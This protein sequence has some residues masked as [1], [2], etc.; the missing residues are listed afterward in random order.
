LT[1]A[2]LEIKRIIARMNIPADVS[3]PK[4]M[5]AESARYVEVH[6]HCEHCEKKAQKEAAQMEN[7]A[8]LW[9]NSRLPSA[10]KGLRFDHMDPERTD[11]TA[12][13]DCREWEYGPR[14]LYLWGATGV[15]KTRLSQCLARREIVNYTRRVLFLGL[16]QLFADLKESF[17]TGSP[18]PRR[19]LSAARDVPL[20]VLDDIGVG[21]S[22]EFGESEIL[23]IVTARL[24]EGLATIYTSNLSWSR[25][26]VVQGFGTLEEKLGARVA[27]RVVHSATAIQ[28][29]GQANWLIK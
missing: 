24:D 19:L 1:P 22:P 4:C 3:C 17:R 2:S 12:I 5:T 25:K 9:H 10:A 7:L 15:G 28:V 21:H 20:L 27:Q 29:T 6:G 8:A 13:Q 23:P 16:P 14:G 11:P 26:N 18:E